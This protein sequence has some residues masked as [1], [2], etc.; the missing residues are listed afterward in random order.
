MEFR[1]QG[2]D[3]ARMKRAAAGRD[4]GTDLPAV[5][6]VLGLFDLSRKD[7]A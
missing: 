4:Y 6:R 7:K 5:S 3:A 1:M 2:R